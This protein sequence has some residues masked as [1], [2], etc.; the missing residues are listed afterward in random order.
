[1]KKAKLM[2]TGLAIV[3]VVGS[4]LAFTAL[5]T[6]RRIFCEAQNGQCTIPVNGRTTS[7]NGSPI[8]DPCAGASGVGDKTVFATSSTTAGCTIETEAVS[9]YATLNN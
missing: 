3:A 4:S 9:V 7:P 8:E 1:M 5:K 6:Q 2:V